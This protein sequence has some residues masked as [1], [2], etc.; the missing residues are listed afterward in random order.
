MRAILLAA[1]VGTR[2]RPLTI[3][4]P[5]ALIKING[6]PMIERQIEFLREVGIK[7]IIIVTGYLNEKFNYLKEKYDVQLIYNNKYDVY[8]NIYT[9]Y[10]VKNY[11]PNSYVID[12]DIYLHKNFFLENPTKSLYFSAKKRNFENEWMLRFHDDLKVYDIE[13]GAKEEDYI[14]SGVSFWSQRDGELLVGKL[15]QAI[16]QGGFSSLY[17]DHIV[18]DNIKDLQV[19]IHKIGSEDVFEVD[20]LKDLKQVEHYLNIGSTLD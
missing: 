5:K 20:S 19:Y 17:W 16:K 6:V 13:V 10:L 18:K 3:N 7:E 12:A 15:D 2:L 9:M 11:L 1:G 14:L 4:T 8:N